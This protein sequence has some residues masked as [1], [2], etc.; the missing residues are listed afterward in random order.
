[1]TTTAYDIPETAESIFRGYPAN[2]AKNATECEKMARKVLESFGL[3]STAS[4]A[5][6][7]LQR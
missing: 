3:P 6:Q 7:Q 2:L 4:S 5:A 1:M